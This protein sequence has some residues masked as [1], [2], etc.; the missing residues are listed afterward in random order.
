MKKKLMVVAVCAILAVS[1][2][3]KFSKKNK[4]HHASTHHAR[5]A[6][7]GKQA[8]GHDDQDIAYQGGAGETKHFYGE[9][10]S[11][12]SQEQLRAKRVYRFG[13]DRYDI[14]GQ[15]FDSLNAHAEYLRKNPGKRIRVEGHTDERGSREYN[16]GLGERRAKALTN[17]FLTKGVSPSQFN[18]V[19]YGEEKPEVNGASEDSYRLN[20]RAVIVYEE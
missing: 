8:H 3:A 4:G 7:V 16:I 20:R 14:S 13:Y 15:D 11:T 10:S 2:C 18:I 19:S 9:E 12:M 5:H 17:L 6:Q 1:G